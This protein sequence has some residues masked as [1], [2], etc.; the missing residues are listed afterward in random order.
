MLLQLKRDEKVTVSHGVPTLLQMIIN[1][2]DAEKTDLTGWKIRIGGSA[3]PKGLATIALS[4]GIHVSAG[5]GMSETGP[6]IAIGYLDKESMA[7]LSDDERT[8]MR[9]KAGKPV[10]FSDVK[11]RND[12][13]EF[14]AHDGVSSGEIVVR[15][16]WVI[17]G[18][19]NDAERSEDVWK[20][21]Y[22][23]TGDI[24][25]IDKSGIVTVI[26]RKKDLIKSGSEWISPSMVE[27][28]ISTYDSVAE[29]TVVAVPD[30]KWEERPLAVIVPKPNENIDEKDLVQFLQQFV[31]SGKIKSFAVPKE[32]HFVS[33]LPKTSTGKIDKK[34]IKISI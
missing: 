14:V 1:H 20:G 8:E 25:T 9:L 26:D 23:H 22:L 30:E 19:F 7:T 3:L 32:Y 6:V 2:P 12:D 13:G 21:G 24:G 27:D 29:V 11:L 34:K 17:Q 28:L 31:T 18:Y 16:P 15:S 10:H 4:K 5:Y 33:G